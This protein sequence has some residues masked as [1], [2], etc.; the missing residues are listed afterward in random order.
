MTSK[1]YILSSTKNINFNFY[2]NILVAKM[3]RLIPRSK[4]RR[5]CSVVSEIDAC[6]LAGETLRVMAEA[7]KVHWRNTVLV[8]VDRGSLVMSFEFREM[9]I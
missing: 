7:M 2:L 5:I 4:S 1:R 3:E 8:F 9:I 6:L